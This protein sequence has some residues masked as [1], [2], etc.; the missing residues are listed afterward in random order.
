MQTTLFLGDSII[1]IYDHLRN[2]SFWYSFS[3]SD[4]VLLI[5]WAF[6]VV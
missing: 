4:N 2:I 5:P 6:L 3:G 1:V